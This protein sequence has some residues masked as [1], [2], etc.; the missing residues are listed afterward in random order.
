[1]PPSPP[2]P[3][4]VSDLAAYQAGDGVM[5]EFAVPVKSVAGDALHEVPTMEVLRGYP[6]ADRTIDEKTFRVVDTIPGAM[7][8]DYVEKG[9]VHF[10]DPIAPE[11]IRAHAGGTTFYRVRARVTDKKTSAI[12]NDASLK[13]YPVAGAID[14]VDAHLTENGIELRWSAPPV[15]SGGGGGG[16]IAEYHLYR[17]EV[18]PAAAGKTAQEIPRVAWKS[19]LLQI[20]ATKTPAYR[21]SA[22]DY[23]KTYVYVVR[24]VLSAEGSSVESSDSR[25]V[26]IKPIDTFPPAAPQGVVAAMIGEAGSGKVVVDLSWSINV[27]PDLAGYRVY[28]SEQQGTLGEALN[29]ELVATPAYR[30][31]SAVSGKKYWYSVK[32]LDRAGN[33]SKA[34]EQVVVP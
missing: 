16:E 26:S 13:L 12:S 21:D 23:G 17:G 3:V 24:T 34:S 22:F 2:I 28:R 4:A 1:M 32:A 25:T 7:L 15:L 6:N 10:L 29:A 11:E 31:G 14:A 8:G 5:L 33:E 27:E 20:A 19:P 18:D 9:K 30:D